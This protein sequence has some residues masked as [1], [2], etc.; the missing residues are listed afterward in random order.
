MACVS[1][2]I[3][4]EFAK[5]TEPPRRATGPK[6]VSEALLSLFDRTSPKLVRIKKVSSFIDL[7]IWRPCPVRDGSLAWSRR[8]GPQP[9]VGVGARGGRRREVTVR[10]F[11][12]R[13]CRGLVLKPRLC[14]GVQTKVVSCLRVRVQPR[15]TRP[16]ATRS[17]AS[18][19]LGLRRIARTS[20]WMGSPN[21]PSM[22]RRLFPQ[23][24][25]AGGRQ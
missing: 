5:A 1:L 22:A 7:G 21:V 9:E 13:L 10:K 4:K 20:R 24:L 2:G 3:S 18:S 14:L 8:N 12:A 19:T 15:T 25:T 16:A 11:A 23:E 17:T 6:S